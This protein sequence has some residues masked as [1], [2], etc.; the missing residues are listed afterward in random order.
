MPTRYRQPLLAIAGLA[1]IALACAHHLATPD[2]IAGDTLTA[3]SL[4]GTT[5]SSP[6]AG[7]AWE[8]AWPEPVISKPEAIRLARRDPWALARLGREW[9]ERNVRDYTCIFLK[10]ERI[11]G[12]LRDVEE[13]EVRYREQPASV[14][15]I[16]RRNAGQARRVLFIDSP[17]FVDKQGRKLARVEPAGA[18]IR[19]V[20]PEVLMPIHGE[21]ARQTSRRF[22]DE[23]GLRSTFELFDRYNGLAAE[24]GVLDLRYA[25]EGEVAGRPTYVIERYLPY[26]GPDGIWPDA[27]LV[28]HLDQRSLLPIAVYSYADREGKVLLGSYVTTNLV[29]NPGLTDAA[30]AF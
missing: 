12:K 11:D 7:T 23:F 14:Y 26:T 27:K 5:E 22:I 10:Q 13:I 15:M 16:W 21:R 20:V 6:A 28:M 9:Y 30:F 17:E 1:V 24:R 25:G 8:S 18:L 2:T 4:A 3:A 19:L 29:L